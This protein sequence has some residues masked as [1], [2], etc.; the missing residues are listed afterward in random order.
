MEDAKIVEET[1][2]NTR[3]KTV[4]DKDLA[5]AIIETVKQLNVFVRA[6]NLRNL[7]V[8]SSLGGLSGDMSVAVTPYVDSIA[9]FSVDSQQKF[10]SID[11]NARALNGEFDKVD[12]SKLTSINDGDTMPTDVADA[13]KNQLTL[14]SEEGEKAN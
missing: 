7:S 11:A 14:V 12:L 9:S 10:N 4:S 2:E 13:G 5:T 6:A 3:Q 1:T 8:D